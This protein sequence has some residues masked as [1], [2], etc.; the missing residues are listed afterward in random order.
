MA[1][2]QLTVTPEEPDAADQP[3]EHRHDAA[4]PVDLSG[5][6]YAFPFGNPPGTSPFGQNRTRRRSSMTRRQHL[7]VISQNEGGGVNGTTAPSVVGN[8][9]VFAAAHALV[10]DAT[11]RDQRRR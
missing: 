8:T 9:K 11:G 4:R 1:Q 5:D 3:V 7:S 6:V 10:A 2:S